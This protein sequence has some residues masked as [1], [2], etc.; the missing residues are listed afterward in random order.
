MAFHNDIGIDG[1]FALVYEL[2]MGQETNHYTI[3][4]FFYSLG[5]ALG[6][7]LFLIMLEA[8]ELQRIRHR[9]RWKCATMRK[10]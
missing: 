4:E 8:E 9:L 7:I 10:M 1:V 3:L 6:I 5:L 2:V